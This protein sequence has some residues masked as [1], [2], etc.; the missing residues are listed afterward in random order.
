MV[1]RLRVLAVVLVFLFTASVTFAAPTSLSDQGTGVTLN[2]DVVDGADLTITLFTVPTGGVAFFTQTFTNAITN[3]TWN[4]Q[5]NESLLTDLEYGRK[6]YKD[7]AIDATDLDFGDDE[8]LAFYSPLGTIANQT[9]L[10]SDLVCGWDVQDTESTT[11]KTLTINAPDPANTLSRIKLGNYGLYMTGSDSRDDQGD[12]GKI[13][14]NESQTNCLN[15]ENN[16]I[17]L[18]AQDEVIINAENTIRL[19]AP[20][21]FS[22]QTTFQTAVIFQSTT[23][24]TIINLQPTN[25]NSAPHEGDVAYYRDG[26]MLCFYNSTDWIGVDGSICIIAIGDT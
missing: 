20:A 13:C 6:Y 21:T 9:L 1:V 8:R 5:L 12:L 2:G 18:T 15:L 4:V 26:H 17:D 11:N 14:K 3:G 19:N 24:H 23:N 10:N 22:D 7:Y 16:N 25:S